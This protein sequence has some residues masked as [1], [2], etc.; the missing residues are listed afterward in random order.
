MLKTSIIII[1]YNNLEYLKQCLKSIK[2]YTAKNSYELIVVDNASDSKTI[3]WLKRQK[4]KVIFNKENLGF[5]K[6]CN[7]GIKLANPNNDILLLNND[8]IVTK[9]WLKNLKICLYS[10]SNIGAVGPV[11]NQNENKQ[12]VNFTYHNF[13]EMQEKAII[14][15]ISNP[16]KWEEKVF[17]IGYALLIK[18]EVIKKIKELDEKYSPGYIEDNDLSISIIKLG[19]KLFLCHDVFIHHYL[20]TSFRK[21]LTKFY[22]ILNKNRHY[23][24]QKWHF[25]TEE[26]DNIKELSLPLINNPTKILDINCGIGTNILFLKYLFPNAII[27]GYETNLAKAN[28]AKYFATIYINYQDIP[29]DKYDYIL[30]GNSLENTNNPQ[31]YLKKIQKYLTD[32]GYIIGVVHNLTNY[33]NIINLLKENDS[34][35]IKHLFSY[36][37]LK[38]LMKDWPNFETYSWYQNYPNDSLFNSLYNINPNIIYT[39][40]AFKISKL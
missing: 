37:D 36:N 30:I 22:P 21:D 10:N 6:G 35:S 16:Q 20:G 17:L 9:N 26:F 5:P 40:Y 4:I 32:N 39:S 23:F 34:S 13:L 25:K 29:L 28:I 24:Y 15:N 14:N 12:G 2:K 27:D 31:K 8:T 18:N 1:S 3:K 11:C 38:K 7:Q 33:N 19:Y